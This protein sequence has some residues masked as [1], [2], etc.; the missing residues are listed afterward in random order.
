LLFG[1]RRC[2]SAGLRT[3]ES[4]LAEL[5]AHLKT[6]LQE[7]EDALCNWQ[8]SPERYQRFRG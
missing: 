3:V 6:G 2:A 5:A 8:K 7:M 4:W 1:E